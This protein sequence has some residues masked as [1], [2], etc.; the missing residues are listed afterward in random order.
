MQFPGGADAAGLGPAFG[1]PLAKRDVPGRKLGGALAS[2]CLLGSLQLEGD[3]GTYLILLVC[4]ANY[5]THGRS[6]RGLGDAADS[7]AEHDG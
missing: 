4:R 7:D 2:W 5:L 6:T 1:G 3:T